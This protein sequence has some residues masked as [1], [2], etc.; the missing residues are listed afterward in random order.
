M[1]VEIT[2]HDAISMG[3]APRP[4]PERM[5][6]NVRFDGDGNAMTKEG[7]PSAGEGGVMKGRTDLVF[8][9]E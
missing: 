1:E 6:V 3:G 5:S 9:L 2:T 7:L 4:F 8:V